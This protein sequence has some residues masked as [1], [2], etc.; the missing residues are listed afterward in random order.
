MIY[1][2]A[3]FASSEH[4]ILRYVI[5]NGE[6]TIERTHNTQSNTKHQTSQTRWFEIRNK[7]QCWT[8]GHLISSSIYS[9]LANVIL[10]TSLICSLHVWLSSFMTKINIFNR[11]SLWYVFDYGIGKRIW[12]FGD[13]ITITKERKRD[14]FRKC[15]DTRLRY[16]K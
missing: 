7:S 10:Q 4:W 5:A 14:V 3:N 6:R 2:F 11:K 16:E 15:C 8:R 9:T 1:L 13:K 12:I